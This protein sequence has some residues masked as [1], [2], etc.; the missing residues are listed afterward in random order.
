MGNIVK[1]HRSSISDAANNLAITRINNMASSTK[2]IC[3]LFLE[4]LI[5]H[6]VQADVNLTAT[7]KFDEQKITNHNKKSNKNQITTKIKKLA[8]IEK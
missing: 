8:N 7:F 5:Y 2:L 1:W 4:K 6:M 3:S